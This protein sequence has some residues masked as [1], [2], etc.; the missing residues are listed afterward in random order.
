[1]IPV[2]TNAQNIAHAQTQRGL[3]EVNFKRDYACLQ[4]LAQTHKGLRVRE[5]MHEPK[6][7][8]VCTN[9]EDILRAQ[10]PKRWRGRKHKEILR[11]QTQ[12]GMRVRKIA[13][14][15]AKWIARA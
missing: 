1:M 13:H 15:K 10:T 11:A 6:I 2:C 4:L 8:C 14:A 7:D 5:I 12:K 3:R 9:A